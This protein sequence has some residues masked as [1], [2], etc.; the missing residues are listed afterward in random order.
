[1]TAVLRRWRATTGVDG[2]IAGIAEADG[3]RLITVSGND[4]DGKQLSAHA[5]LKLN[6]ITKLF[7]AN[8]VYRAAQEGRIDL[9]ASVPPLAALAD[10]RF[11]PSLTPRLLLQHR[12]GLRGYVDTGRYRAD[13]S[14]ISSPAEAIREGL[15]EATGTPGGVPAYSSTNYLVLGELLEQVYDLPYD[16]L[17]HQRL[18]EP[19]ALRRTHHEP[20]GPGQPNGGT[21]GLT[22]DIGDL[23]T[24][25]A[26]LLREHLGL[27]P[28]SISSMRAFDAETGIGAG[29]IGYC[30]CIAQPDGARTFSFEGHTGSSNVIVFSPSTGRT[31]ALQ[32]TGQL[33]EGDRFG[34]VNELLV[35]LA[36]ASLR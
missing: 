11:G 9:D 10:V 28:A 6:S 35:Q 12:S 2:V 32:I 30:P 29:A 26:G 33:F 15:A 14:S 27:T 13:P 17:L 19:L 24:A 16:V 36:V 22:A 4:L 21:G 23:L 8:L 25:G 34:Q 20:P 18:L 31:I 1:M 3:R 7:T 5:P